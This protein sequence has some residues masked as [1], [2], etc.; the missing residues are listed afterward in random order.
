MKKVIIGILAHVDAGKTTLSEAM[1]YTAGA[2]RRIGR[3][4]NQ[5][6]FLDTDTIERERGITIFAKQA[7]LEVEELEITL[8]DTPGHVDFSAEMERTL[9]VLDYAILV[10]SGADGVQGHTRTLWKLLKLYQ[11]PTFIF[12]NKMDQPG[13]DKAALM[14][15]IRERL[16]EAA[17]DFSQPDADILA[18]ELACCDERVLEE[19]LADGSLDDATI[20]ELIAGRSVFPCYFGSAL[21]LDGVEAFMQGLNRYVV[22]PVYSEE[23]A[24]RVFKISRDPQGNRL[25]HMKITGGELHVKAQPGGG[26][27]AGNEKV[28]QIRIYSGEKFEA[29]DLAEAGTICAV[30]GLTHTYPGAGLGAEH[31]MS[32]PVL[33]PVLTYR[34]ILPEEV[35]AAVLLPKLKELEEEEPELH[36]EWN[37]ELGEIQAQLMGEVQT[38]ILK[39]KISD[40]CGTE[41]SF[42]TGNIIYKETITNTVEGVGHFEPLRHYAE[43][44]LLLEPLPAGSGLVF[45]STCSI[46][47]LDHNWQQAILFH[48]Q[49]KEHRGVL[50]GSAITDMKITLVAGRA[51]NKHTEGGDFRQAALRAVRQGLM[52]ADSV[53]LEPYF[54]FR[55]EVPEAATGRA[56]ADIERMKGTFTGPEPADGRMILTGTAPV[57]RM[58]HY[59]KEVMTY[60]RGEGQLFCEVGGY[61]PAH[62]A[63]EVI[64]EMDYDPLRDPANPADSI[65][66]AHGAGFPVP[67]NEVKAH[68]HIESQLKTTAQPEAAALSDHHSS[69]EERA[70]G[71]EEIDAIL[72]RA[73][74]A[75]RRPEHDPDKEKRRIRR[76]QQ[77]VRSGGKKLAPRD[78]YLLVD[79]YNIIF[80]WD[81]L[82]VLAEHDIAAARG[83]LQ[84]VLCN[85][86]AIRKCHLIV[87][88]DAY[89]VSGGKM[90]STDYHNIHVV[91]TKEAETADQY[92]E[93]FA[94][95][96]QKKYHVTVA[97]SDGVEQVII[98][99]AGSSL[100]SA[101]ELETEIRR[102]SEQV[103]EEYREHQP[104]GGKTFLLDGWNDQETRS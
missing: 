44:H 13:T 71:V 55:L 52:E 90:S 23:F 31:E 94:Q 75:N 19:Y 18:E 20:S 12:I 8:M 104:P 66:C 82:R 73:T 32:G 81:E 91:Y 27:Q 57:A 15:D 10:I 24:A 99:G 83:R 77:P 4:D 78:E 6:A 67:W 53:L 93:R 76:Y 97:T 68:M 89:R 70:I 88:F 85:Y 11:I 14:A 51:H 54:S 96:N 17:I 92:I 98:R 63:G 50:T 43:V 9:A 101:R 100:I 33:K 65:F 61:Q 2:I 40:R 37:E 48:L 64:A 16:D 79:G 25:T 103:Q 84:D 21:K 34:I 80:A 41:V 46:D 62:N 29:T 22:V 39:R 30:T 69:S 58:Q 3:V 38:E 72:D 56:I 74:S 59:H 5:D 87:V 47:E 1:L 35:D 42:G 36:I 49:E 86:Q 28:N 45:A 102:V 60:T 95:E 7:Q 26:K